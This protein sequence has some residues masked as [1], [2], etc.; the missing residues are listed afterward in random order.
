[1]TCAFL[2]QEQCRA[3]EREKGQLRSNIRKVSANWF[4]RKARTG[5]EGGGERG[6]GGGEGGERGGGEGEGERGGRGG[7]VDTGDADGGGR[8]KAG[9][10][11]REDE[12]T[13]GR[14]R[15]RGGGGGGGGDGGDKEVL[16]HSEATETP[17]APAES[18]RE[19][20]D[21]KE[22]L[23]EGGESKPTGNASGGGRD[24]E[25]EEEDDDEER[26]A[27]IRK[28]QDIPRLLTEVS[29]Q[30]YK[31]EITERMCRE[32]RKRVKHYETV[33]DDQEVI[34]HGLKD[35]LQTYFS[36]NQQMAQQLSSFSRVFEDLEVSERTSLSTNLEAEGEGGA[37][38]SSSSGLYSLPNEDDLRQMSSSVS[39]TYIK[40]RDLIYEKKSLITEIDRL[41]V[42]N[43]ELQRRVEQ[44]ESRLEGVT[45]ALHSTWLLV[46]NMKEEH[47]KLHTSESILRYEL[48]G[49]RE[50]LQHLK[51]E[52]ECSRDQW[53]RIRQMNSESEDE[54]A[55]MREEL[56]ARR[57]RR[58]SG[59][60]GG[61]GGGGGGEAEGAVG[62]A[63]GGV[64]AVGGAI[65]SPPLPLPPSSD[66][67]EPPVD[68]LLDMAIEYG[69]VDAEDDMA[70]GIVAAME[71]EDMHAS[72]LRELEDQCSYLYHKLMSSTSRS[73]A[74]A[75]RLSALHQQY[76]DEDEDEDDYDEDEDGD[77]YYEEEDEEEEEE[78]EEEADEGGGEGYPFFESDSGVASPSRPPPTHLLPSPSQDPP[79]ASPSTN[80][81]SSNPTT[82][83]FSLSSNTTNALSDTPPSPSSPSNALSNTPQEDDLS[84]RLINF[85]PRKIEILRRENEKLEEKV[86]QLIEEKEKREGEKERE[87]EEKKREEERKREGEERERKET[88]ERDRRR[89]EMEQM[90]MELET[91]R[92][93]RKQLEEKLHHLG[94]CVDELKL[95]RNGQIIEAEEKLRQKVESLSQREK[96]YSTLQ[97]D[98]ETLR[99]KYEERGNILRIAN[100]RVGQLENCERESQNKLHLATVQAAEL[101]TAH[102][103]LNK[104][105]GQLKKEVISIREEMR[106][107]RE[108]MER[109][110]AEREEEQEAWRQK[111]EA[112]EEAESRVS[113]LEDDRRRLE[114]Q[115]E[116][117]EEAESRVSSL[118]D[119]RRRLEEQLEAKERE[120]EEEERRWKKRNGDECGNL[121]EKII[122][123]LSRRVRA[124]DECFSI[125]AELASVVASLPS[126]STRRRRRRRTEG[127]AD[128]KNKKREEREEGG[129]MAE[130][131]REE[132][133]EEDDEEEEDE[134]ESQECFTKPGSSSGGEA[135]PEYRAS[136]ALLSVESLR[137]KPLVDAQIWVNAGYRYLIPVNL[138]S[139][140]T[141]HWCFSA[142]PKSVGFAVLHQPEVEEKFSGAKNDQERD[143]ERDRE[144]HQERYQERDRERDQPASSSTL[145][146]T[147]PSSS[148]V[149]ISTS[150]SSPST[151]SPSTSST[152][153][154]RVLIPTTRVASAQGAAM[155]GRL[156]TKQPGVYTFLFD[157]S[158]ARYTAK[159]VLFSLEIEAKE[160]T[161]DEEEI[162]DE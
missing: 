98:L 54:W 68:L 62:G 59:G 127:E 76:G 130:G 90:K 73:L 9:G 38:D 161:G 152:S 11:G 131:E 20:S 118:E 80:T 110:G 1:M 162:P 34:I 149:A 85:L 100:E 30:A 156:S 124:C 65:P 93:I 43:L 141:L 122:Q 28:L 17:P 111:A 16:G 153:L 36:D 112:L 134:E 23:A 151:S 48:K 42:L 96:E 133:E 15:G 32:L 132:E 63:E 78:E 107:M 81:L 82:S 7:R 138:P 74:L 12:E 103:E 79:Q 109:K 92:R 91:E 75:S 87:E 157:N 57:R 104:E 144:R 97:E 31:L 55:S 106:R 108:E 142:E 29:F 88:E 129:G 159:R 10:E 50:L 113:S 26:Q 60:E 67:F 77:I 27:I 139:G 147:V 66:K 115:L 39:R 135:S 21:D 99:E 154:H 145:P 40:L 4:E 24:E 101:K 22:E 70:T 116:A 137:E 146:S 126:Q 119:D 128:A 64:G 45:D 35:Q 49:K 148:S 19:N 33:I 2:L 46:S 150:T 117:L 13:K 83:D 121:R 140:V 160:E 52:L 14:G 5:S 125:R 155:K 102:E 123:I 37:S 41:K 51:D 86:R 18:E 58:G 72:R 25:E 47:A 56:N 89:K 143:Q 6:G 3:S 61:E 71:G 158:Y 8:V 120:E 84:K 94:K 69:V 53:H 95:E 114:E 136:S 44:Q 105:Y